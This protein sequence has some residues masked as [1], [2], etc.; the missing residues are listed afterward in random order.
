MNEEVTEEE[1]S[2][3]SSEKVLLVTQQ[4]SVRDIVVLTLNILAPSAKIL[5]SHK[6]RRECHQGNFQGQPTEKA[7]LF[8]GFLAPVPTIK[9]C[10]NFDTQLPWIS[11]STSVHLEI[12]IKMKR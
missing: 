8:S 2:F 12:K 11:I 7:Y 4:M 10:L 1:E 6:G 3:W 9:D 5:Q